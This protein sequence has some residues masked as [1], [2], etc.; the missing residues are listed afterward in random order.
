MRKNSDKM[1]S[2]T[3]GAGEFNELTVG[4][5]QPGR[6]KNMKCRNSDLNIRMAWSND[7]A[8]MLLLLISW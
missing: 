1:K 4:Q 8:E 7:T 5:N 2:T 6:R 3:Y